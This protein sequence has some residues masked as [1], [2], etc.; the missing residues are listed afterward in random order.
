[1]AQPLFQ[2]AQTPVDGGLA[3]AQSFGRRKPLRTTA[4]KYL[5]SFQSNA[6]EL[7]IFE[8][9]AF[10]LAAPRPTRSVPKFCAGRIALRLHRRIEN[11]DEYIS[12]RQVWP[13]QR[14]CRLGLP[15]DR[16]RI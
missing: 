15:C 14:G 16:L 11:I 3:G 5:R 12:G 7:V 10:K 2:L 4:K 6:P 8:S 13:L 9:P 1:V